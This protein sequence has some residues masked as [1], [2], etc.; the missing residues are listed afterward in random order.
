MSRRSLRVQFPGL[1][2][3]Q[4]AG[5]LELPAHTP[6]GFFLFSHCFTCS[7]D[8]KAI[9]KLSRALADYGWGVLRYDFT[10]LGNSQGEFEHTNFTTNCRD[11]YAAVQF[12]S[13]EHTPPEFLIGH[14]FGGAASL[15]MAAE[16]P[17]VRGVVALGAPSDTKHLADLLLRM[18]PAIETHGVGTVVIGGQSFRIQHQMV[19]DFRSHDLPGRVAALDK[20]ILALH[21]PTDETVNYKHALA[22]CGLTEMPTSHATIGNRTLVN[23]P[24]CNHLFTDKPESIPFAVETIDHWCRNWFRPDPSENATA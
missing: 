20:P 22:N 14:S 8:L 10:G 11:L 17:S 19:V 21:S 5:I 24:M 3:N 7:K 23:L 1:N 15:A 4:L 6:D 2:G 12:L 16:L 9:V 18:D 13:N